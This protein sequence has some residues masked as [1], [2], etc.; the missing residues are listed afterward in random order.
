MPIQPCAG[1]LLGEL[2]RVA[3]DP[4]VVVTAEAGDGIGGDGSGLLAERASVR[5]SRRSP[6]L[7]DARCASLPGRELA[8]E[9]RASAEL[10]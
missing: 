8:V 9:G 7:F 1:Q 3:V 6:S 4:R 5:V 10:V 2:L